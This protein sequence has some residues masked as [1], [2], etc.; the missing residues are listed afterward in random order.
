MHKGQNIFLFPFTVI[1]GSI[2]F[3]CPQGMVLFLIDKPRTIHSEALIS[4]LRPLLSAFRRKADDFPDFSPFRDCWK[5]FTNCKKIIM[6]QCPCPQSSI[7][8]HQS[9]ASLIHKVTKVPTSP[10]RAFGRSA[11]GVPGNRHSYRD[12]LSHERRS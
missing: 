7:D 2:P 6:K 11:R 12:P 9:Y 8:N 1:K 5:K 10:I 4:D 3:R